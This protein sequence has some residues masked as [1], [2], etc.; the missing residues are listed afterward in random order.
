MNRY[1]DGDWHPLCRSLRP[2]GRRTRCVLGYAYLVEAV[3]ELGA[4]DNSEGPLEQF[5]QFGTVG[6]ALSISGQAGGRWVEPKLGTEPLPERL[7]AAGDLHDPVRAV[8]QPV[9]RDR[10]VVVALRPRDLARHRPPSAL[11]GV[12]PD[13]RSEQ[14]RPYHLPPASPLALKKGG[15]DAVHAGGE[16]T[17]RHADALRVAWSRT[18]RL[19]LGDLVIARAAALRPVVSEPG[20]RQDD[21]ARVELEKPLARKAETV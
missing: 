17:D 14:R 10:R 5:E 12:Y 16:V 3:Q 4:G 11:E 21:Q 20:D 15:E 19:A 13:E 1:R 6:D 9:G 2:A 7:V 18:R 8:K